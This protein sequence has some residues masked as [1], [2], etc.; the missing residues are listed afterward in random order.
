[1]MLVSLALATSGYDPAAPV[2]VYTGSEVEDIEG[3]VRL[4]SAIELHEDP[5]RTLFDAG[6][7]NS[8]T[9]WPSDASWAPYIADCF[10]SQTPHTSRFLLHVGP[11]AAIASGTPVLFV[12]GAADNGSRGFITMAWHED[13]LGKPVYAM[14]F[15]HPHGDVFQQ[16]E[17]I[18]DAIA[19]IKA[20]TGA[21]QVDVVAHSKGGIAAAIYASNS[22]GAAWGGAY[23]RVGTPY[24]GDVRR[25]VL[26][27]TP[28]KGIDTAFRWSTGNYLSLEADSTFSPSAWEDY[29]PY[30]TATSWVSDDLRAQDFYAEEGDLFPGHRQIYAR[31]D[32]PLPGS[33]SWLGPY[34]AQLD[35]YT[36]Y[37]GGYGFYTYSEGIDGVVAAGG[38][39][40]AALQQNGVDPA[41]EVFLLSGSNPLMP[42]GYEDWAA[43]QFGEGWAEFGKAE[44]ETWADVIAS[45]VG[46]GA[47][48]AEL[49]EEELQGV[50]SGDLVIGEISG[51]SDGL[52]FL[53]SA[54]DESML[55]ARGAV[56]VDSHIANLSHLDLLY[57][58]P[59][60]GELLVEAGA[61]DDDDAW[62]ISFGE[63]YTEEDTI[64]LVEGW[65]ADGDDGSG[66]DPGD[67]GEPGA[68]DT[69]GV[70]TGATSDLDEGQD[71]EEPGTLPEECGAC[72]G[73]QAAP[74]LLGLVAAILGLRRRR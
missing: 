42:N 31:Q 47:M 51:Q 8:V 35:W 43:T 49:T 25:L 72:N 36:T 70:D 38:G 7:Y 22:G 37:E 71:A 48:S 73:G 60:T 21:A 23:D 16:A 55:T 61:A 69:G 52:V 1:M 10:Q 53:D 17:Q 26:I 30:G 58:S 28:L 2:E 56:V 59:I 65:L 34:A 5:D 12:P 68:S 27:A 33:L 15:A 40:L 54:S 3:S 63:R 64:G 11:S 41:V 19:R 18:A 46:E 29:Y 39:V 66:G 20:R 4:W 6:E 74:G 32:H 50:L 67:T 62:M 14:T 45:A 44:R 9:A 24:Q 57:A 13:L